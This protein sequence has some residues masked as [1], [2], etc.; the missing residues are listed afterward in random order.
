MLLRV[1]W[2]RGGTDNVGENGTINVNN[3]IKRKAE[4]FK[5]GLQYTGRRRNGWPI[6]SRKAIQGR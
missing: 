4:V 5:K 3:N 2:G 1:K 6:S